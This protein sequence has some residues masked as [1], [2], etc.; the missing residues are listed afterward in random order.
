[1]PLHHNVDDD[2]NRSSINSN[3]DDDVDYSNNDGNDKVSFLRK[4]LPH[5]WSAFA[6]LHVCVMLDARNACILRVK[7]QEGEV[8][9]LLEGKDEEKGGK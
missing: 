4:N 9:V 5:S 2:D 8:G 1:M 6:R 7:K 3:N